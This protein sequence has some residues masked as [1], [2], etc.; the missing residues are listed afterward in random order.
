MKKRFT[1]LKLF[2]ILAKR[3]YLY[4]KRNKLGWSWRDA[5]KFTSA[6]LYQNYKSIKTLSSLDKKSVD[7]LIEISLVFPSSPLPQKAAAPKVFKEVCKNPKDYASSFFED[8]DWFDIEEKLSVFDG[9]MYMQLSLDLNGVSIADT[10]VIKKRDLPNLITIR[11]EIRKEAPGSPVL[12]ISMNIMVRDGK[13]DDDQPCSY[14]VLVTFEGSPIL[15]YLQSRMASTTFKPTKEMSAEEMERIR[16]QQE[17]AAKSRKEQLS[18]KKIKAIK[19][20]KHVEPKP[21]VPK[22]PE[23][24]KNERLKEYNKAV[25]ELKKLLKD[26]L[27]TN[28]QFSKRFDELGKNLKL[29]GII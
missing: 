21:I 29:G 6:N 24:L 12:Q 3:A 22:T 19:R 4:S 9:D 27:I 20:P 15:G 11:E 28:K 14:Y 13:E 2:N 17:E 10:P 5:Q 1:G 16:Q 7:R 18:K 26:G 25:K 23:E 8:F